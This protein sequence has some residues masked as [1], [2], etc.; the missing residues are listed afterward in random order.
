MNAPKTK[1]HPHTVRPAVLLSGLAGALALATV[2]A[3]CQMLLSTSVMVGTSG[4]ALLTLLRKR[5]PS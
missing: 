4:L 3:H 5:R 1:T 2:F